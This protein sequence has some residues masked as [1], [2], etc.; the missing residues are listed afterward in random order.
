MLNFIFNIFNLLW[1]TRKLVDINFLNCLSALV[2]LNHLE[3]TMKSLLILYLKFSILF[4]NVFNLLWRSSKIVDIS[5]FNCLNG[6][7]NLNHL[8]INLKSLSSYFIFLKCSILFNKIFKL[9][10]R[11]N[12]IAHISAFNC[13]SALVNLNHL[14]FHL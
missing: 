12:R 14:E 4:N 1:R 10:W 3:L 11:E 2:N 9:H 5:G 6:L 8:K 13:L 7:A